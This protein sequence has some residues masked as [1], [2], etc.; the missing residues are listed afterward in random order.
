MTN[1]SALSR[2][3]CLQLLD[4]ASYPDWQKSSLIRSLEPEDSTRT[5]ATLQPGDKIKCD[6]DGM[7]FT[8]VIKVNFHLRMRIS[9]ATFMQLTRDRRQEN[10]ERLF[11]WQGPPVMGLIAG[12]HSFGF[13]TTESGG[14][15][16]TQ[17]EQF[18]GPISFLMGPSL[19]GRKMLGQ[20]RK[21]NEE[22]KARAERGSSS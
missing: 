5:L 15:I 22:L 8:A 11:Q 18:S 14:T 13:A 12:L 4:F 6:I 2:L 19:L 1:T 21:F 7:K 9:T 10:S 17:T 20:Y 3:H 16:F